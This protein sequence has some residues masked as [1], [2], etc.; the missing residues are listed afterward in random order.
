MLLVTERTSCGSCALAHSPPAV[1]PPR[2][3]RRGRPP[4]TTPAATRDRR[5]DPYPGP[6]RGPARPAREPAGTPAT[7]GTPRTSHDLLRHL[8]G[9]LQRHPL[10]LPTLTPSR[11]HSGRRSLHRR[12][13][14]VGMA[15]DRNI[16]SFGPPPVLLE[17]GAAPQVGR[18][19]RQVA[20]GLQVRDQ[21]DSYRRTAKARLDDVRAGE[22]GLRRRVAP[23][24]PRQYREAGGLA[25]PAEGKLGHRER[26]TCRAGPGISNPG[27]IEQTLQAA[28]LSRAAMTAH[29]GGSNLDPAAPPE[30][31]H[32]METGLATPQLQ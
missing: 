2:Q 14:G 25:H 5:E 32:L 6:A 31:A 20:S 1:E 17:N 22:G 19:L 26:G 23:A 16:I 15:R 3:A 12:T 28:V 29:D 21:L 27:Q 18:V 8:A 9:V 30:G 7:A 4:R 13:R 10:P 24:D 11:V